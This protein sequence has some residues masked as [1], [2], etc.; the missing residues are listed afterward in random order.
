MKFIDA[1]YNFDRTQL[2]LIFT[3]DTRVDFRVL[4]KE[5]ASLYI[6]RIEL[7]QIGVRD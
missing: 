1:S 6:T 5:L 4:A 7:R 3:A 2:L